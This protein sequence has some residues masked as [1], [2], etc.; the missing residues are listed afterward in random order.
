METETRTDIYNKLISVY[1]DKI[2]YIAKLEVLKTEEVD[3]M[4]QRVTDE[5]LY[6][7]PDEEDEPM[8]R[9]TCIGK[10]DGKVYTFILDK[11]EL[12]FE[13]NPEEVYYYFL[14]DIMM[15]E[16][17]GDFVFLY[18]LSDLKGNEA[19][20]YASMDDEQIFIK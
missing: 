14:R 12:D 13:F 2:H 18:M 6:I 7:I 9:V 10:Y 8:L 11:D 3:G 1:D 16:K 15:T 4:M 19:T 17:G 20:L 5:D